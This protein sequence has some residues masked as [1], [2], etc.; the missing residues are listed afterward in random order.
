M[1]HSGHA[2]AER[3]ISAYEVPAMGYIVAPSRLASGWVHLRSSRRKSL[4]IP[5]H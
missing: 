1:V 4:L 3:Q 5:G 2:T